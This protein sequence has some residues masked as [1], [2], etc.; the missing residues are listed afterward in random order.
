MTPISDS[1]VENSTVNNVKDP[2]WLQVEVCREFQRGKCTR[3]VSECRFAHPDEN[4][5]VE[6]GGRVTACFDS[7]KDRCQRESCKY[8]HPPHHIKLQL[9]A[10][11]R[12][13]KQHKQQLQ[14][15]ASQN[16]LQT[17]AT[18]LPLNALQGSG[19]SALPLTFVSSP[20]LT[21]SSPRNAPA[22][23]TT[24][25]NWRTEKI[26]PFLE[27]C[28]DYVNG[29]CSSNES[30]CSA[31]HPPLELLRDRNQKRITVC[32]DFVKGRCQ[33][34]SCRYFHPPSH[35]QG[36]LKTVKISQSQL[37]VIPSKSRKRPGESKDD[38]EEQAK[39]QA[40]NYTLIN[41]PVALPAANFA[42]NFA[43][44]FQPSAFQPTNAMQFAPAF[45]STLPLTVPQL[46][47]TT[48]TPFVH[49]Q[50]QPDYNYVLSEPA[51]GVFYGYQPYYPANGCQYISCTEEQG[52]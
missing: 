2:R 15:I 5:Q 3:E 51:T 34:E 11:G 23:A 29:V 10:N 52:M 16:L 27:V 36:K 24:N 32:M 26:L 40:L 9:E 14:A 20:V 37:S 47:T 25:S 21:S 28:N 48:A 7:M 31:A 49:P 41:T 30:Q 22:V 44:I 13:L 50:V 6:N 8:F 45:F 38:L 39:Q 17:P 35:L 19:V 33:R 4:V 18:V 1:F 46:T 43:T 42:T 12:L